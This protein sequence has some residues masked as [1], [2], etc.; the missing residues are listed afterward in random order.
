MRRDLLKVSEAIGVDHPA[1]ITADDVDCV[2]GLRSSRSIAEIYGYP[3]GCGQVGPEL[4][5]EITR[6]MAP[7]VPDDD[8][9]VR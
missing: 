9:P 3:P 1:L 8:M 7:K 2:D 6:I 5:E 4:A